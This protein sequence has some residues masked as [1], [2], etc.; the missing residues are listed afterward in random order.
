MVLLLAVVLQGMESEGTGPDGP[1][2]ALLIGLV[3]F[4][5]RQAPEASLQLF[6]QVSHIGFSSV[7]C[8]EVPLMRNFRVT[9]WRLYCAYVCVRQVSRLLKGLPIGTLA[10]GPLDKRTALWSE[11]LSSLLISVAASQASVPLPVR[12]QAAEACF[13]VIIDIVVVVFT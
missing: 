12:S 11:N 4:Q 5:S 9:V 8:V 13:S 1:L 7:S 3:D 6:Q 2:F 10:A